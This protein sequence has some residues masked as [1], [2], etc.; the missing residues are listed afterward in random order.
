MKSTVYLVGAGPGDPGL[1]TVKG[2]ELI[3]D[4]DAI[5][6]DYLANDS[7]LK[8]TKKECKVIYAGKGLGFKALSQKQI[9]KKHNKHM[10][11]KRK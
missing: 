3:S 10:G 7:F 11:N 8:L 6:Y 2:I 1:I 4:A 9:N 5:V